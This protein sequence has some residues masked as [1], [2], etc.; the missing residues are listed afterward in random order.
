MLDPIREGVQEAKVIGASVEA[1]IKTVILAEL[2]QVVLTVQL[3]LSPGRSSESGICPA[4]VSLGSIK[5]RA[6]DLDIIG[7]EPVIIDAT[8]TRISKTQQH[9]TSWQIGCQ[10]DPTTAESFNTISLYCRVCRA[11]ANCLP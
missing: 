4:C 11:S 7:H 8:I 2:C 1:V 6:A 3:I 5:R 9:V 10:I